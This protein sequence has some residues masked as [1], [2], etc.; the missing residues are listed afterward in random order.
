MVPAHWIEFATPVRCHVVLQWEMCLLPY[1]SLMV[2]PHFTH[3]AREI[4]CFRA[5]CSSRSTKLPWL[6]VRRRI[7]TSKS[8]PDAL[9]A[10][11]TTSSFIVRHDRLLRS[12]T[13][14]PAYQPTTPMFSRHTQRP[15]RRPA[16]DLLAKRVTHSVCSVGLSSALCLAMT[17]IRRYRSYQTLFTTT[18]RGHRLSYTLASGWPAKGCNITVLRLSLA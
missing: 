14:C 6:R 10:T 8:L 4:L 16:C 18:A 7:L 13:Q 15:G 9:N 17:R 5:N 2:V 11:S 12:I 3:Y 1:L